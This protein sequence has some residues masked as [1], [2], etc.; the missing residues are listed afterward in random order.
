MGGVTHV[1]AVLNLSPESR[2][3]HTVAAS[4]EEALAVARR[5]R[6]EGASLIDLGAQS[7]HYANPTLSVGEELA[8]L[9]PALYL[10]V[11]DGFLVSIDTW[12]PEVARAA[13]EAGAVIVNDTGGLADPEMRAVVRAAQAPAVLVYVEGDH[14][15]AVGEI[16]TRPDKAGSIAEWMAERVGGLAAEGISDLVFDP[17][18]AIN[19]P[20]DYEAYTRVQVEVVRRLDLFRALGRPVLVPIP[21][22]REDHRVMAYITLAVEHGADL[23]RVHDVAQA[24]DLVRLLGR[25]P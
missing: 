19:Y 17:G 12:K 8:R 7:S 2:N 25:A 22:K 4:P 14:P 9:L 13:L 16:D 18:I 24:C 20:G 10:L 6:Q 23:V 1:M 5:Y 15:H 3:S 21:R 11:D